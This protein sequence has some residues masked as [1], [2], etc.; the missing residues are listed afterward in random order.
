[1]IDCAQDN[2]ILFNKFEV[3]LT[4]GFRIFDEGLKLTE[5]KEATCKLKAPNN[6]QINHIGYPHSFAI[7]FILN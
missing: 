5:P 4:A 2:V 3:N 6:N 7:I 1:L